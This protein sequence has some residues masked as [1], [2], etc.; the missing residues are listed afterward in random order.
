MSQPISFH[1]L[2]DGFSIKGKK[3]LRSWLER[4]ISAHHFVPG[5]I[6]IIYCSDN[7]LA[8]MN[9]DYLQHD[10]FTDIITFNY[11]VGSQVSGDIFISI[12]RVAENAASFGATLENE[13][14]RVMVHGVLHL[15]GYGEH[16]MRSAEDHFLSWLEEKP[17]VSRETSA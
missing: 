13:L 5:E 12:D 14:C 8:E 6:S 2:V 1:S 17:R 15:L 7:Y 10:T 3:S 4:V 16:A 11:N 9:Q